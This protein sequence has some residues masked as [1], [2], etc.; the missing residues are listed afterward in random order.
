MTSLCPSTQN[1]HV[2]KNSARYAVTDEYYYSHRFGFIEFSMQLKD[3]Y[4]LELQLKLTRAFGPT[5]SHRVN[6]AG[7][8]VLTTS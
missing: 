8:G 6:V 1:T 3:I 2:M 4:S 5:L 7:W